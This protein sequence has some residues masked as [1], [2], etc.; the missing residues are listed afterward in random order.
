MG[1]ESEYIS[2]AGVTEDE[3]ATDRGTGSDVVCGPG[4]VVN[5]EGKMWLRL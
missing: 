5:G 3:S 4:S 1:E 2:L